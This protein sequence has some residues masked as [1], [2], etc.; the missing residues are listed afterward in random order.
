MHVSRNKVLTVFFLS[1]VPFLCWVLSAQGGTSVIDP[2]S[3]NQV[4][5]S[6]YDAAFHYDDCRTNADDYWDDRGENIGSQGNLTDAVTGKTMVGLEGIQLSNDGKNTKGNAAGEDY[7]L[8]FD[9]RSDITFKARVYVLLGIRHVFSET[10]EAAVKA[11]FDDDAYSPNKN[12]DSVHTDRTW[13]GLDKDGEPIASAPVFDK[14]LER[15]DGMPMVFMARNGIGEE[16]FAFYHDFDAGD[17]VGVYGGYSGG[18][19]Y[20]VFAEPVPSPDEPSTD[21]LP[22][23]WTSVE[24]GDDAKPGSAHFDWTNSEWIISGNGHDVWDSAD[25]FQYVYTEHSGDFTVQARFNWL[26]HVGND[27]GKIGLMVRDSADANSAHASIASRASNDYIGIQYRGST[28]SG[29]SGGL[30]SWPGAGVMPKWFRW[31]RAGN[32]FTGSL[33]DDGVNWTTHGSQDVTL[34]DPV[35]VGMSVTSHITGTLTTASYSNTYITGKGQVFAHAGSDQSVDQGAADTFDLNGDGCIEADEF[36][37][38]QLAGA[39][40]VIPDPSAQ[41]QTINTAAIDIFGNQTFVFRLT[42]TNT[43]SGATQTATIQVFVKDKEQADAGADQDAAESKTGAIVTVHLD[44]SATTGVITEW[45]W[46][47]VSGPDV[48]PIYNPDKPNPWFF[49]GDWAGDQVIQFRLTING[50]EDTDYVNINV[51]DAEEAIA[52]A[53]ADQE[54]FE[55]R[56]PLGLLDAT[57][58][59]TRDGEPSTNLS[60]WWDQVGGPSVYKFEG[61]DTT[62]PTFIAPEIPVTIRDRREWPPWRDLTFRVTV[63]A[64]NGSTGSD[65][66]TVTIKDHEF[67]TVLYR[68]HEDFD[69]HQTP[70]DGRWY[71]QEAEYG[72]HYAAGAVA[73]ELQGAWARINPNVDYWW[74]NWG[75]DHSY[76]DGVS[77]GTGGQVRDTSG[78]DWKCGWINPNEDDFWKYTFELPHGSTDAYLV[79]WMSS[80]SGDR[81]NSRMYYDYEQGNTAPVS[82]VR[83]MNR[84]WDNFFPRLSP[85]FEVTAGLHKIMIDAQP[86]GEPNY[87]RFELHLPMPHGNVANAGPDQGAASGELVVLNGT[88]SQGVGL[89]YTWEQVSG[90]PVT[91]AD[92]GSGVATFTAP[93]VADVV[94]LLFRLTVSGATNDSSDMVHVTVLPAGLGFS[95]FAEQ[96]TARDFTTT[97]WGDRGAGAGGAESGP[98]LETYGQNNRGILPPGYTLCSEVAAPGNRLTPNVV[99]HYNTFGGDQNND[100]YSEFTFVNPTGAGDYYYYMRAAYQNGDS[101]YIRCNDAIVGVWPTSN[102]DND[103]HRIANDNGGRGEYRYNWAKVRAN[104]V[105]LIDGENVVRIYGRESH[106]NNWMPFVWDAM[107]FSLVELDRG[108]FDQM[109]TIARAAQTGTTVNADAGAD[110]NV[111]EGQTAVLDGTGSSGPITSWQWAQTAGPGVTIT[112]D[113]Q[114]VATFV[115]PNVSGPTTATFELTVSD[116]TNS[117]SDTVDVLILEPGPPPPPTNLAAEGVELGIQLTWDASPGAVS[118]K[119]LRREV[120][121]PWPYDVLVAENFGGT[122]LPDTSM[123]IFMDMTY[124]YTVLGVNSFGVS[125]PAIPAQA[126][127]L[128]NNLALRGDAAPFAKRLRGGLDISIMNNEVTEEIIENDVNQESIDS[129]AGAQNDDW[130]GYWYPQPMYFQEFH[131]HPGNVLPDGGWWTSLGVQFTKDGVFWYDIP[132]ATITID[133]LYKFTPDTPDDR[134]PGDGRLPHVRKH[135]ISFP[136]VEGIA[137]RISGAPG[138]TADYTSVA[139]LKLYGVPG[140]EGYLYAFAGPDTSFDEGTTATLDGSDSATPVAVA[141]QWEQITGAGGQVIQL[142]M[143]SAFNSDVIYAEGEDLAAHDAFEPGG[144]NWLYSSNA[145]IAPAGTTPLPAD[146]VLGPFQLGPSAGNNNNCL[147]LSD[148]QRSGT[149]PVT[150]GNYGFLDVVFS[151]ASGNHWTRLYLNYANGD[152]LIWFEFS[153]W[154]NRGDVE[155]ALQNSFRVSRNDEHTGYGTGDPGGPNLYRRRIPVD[156]TRTLESITFS[157]FPG[158]GNQTGGVFAMNLG[159]AIPVLDLQNANSAVC[160]FNVPDMTHDQVVTFKLTVWDASNNSATDE[161]DVLLVDTQGSHP[162]PG[163]DATA[164]PFTSH[165]LDGSGTG[166]DIVWYRWEQIGGPPPV[167]L[168]N[169]DQAQ[170][171]IIVPPPGDPMTFKLT[172]GAANGTI[173]S[174]TVTISSAYPLNPDPYNIVYGPAALSAFPLVPSSGYIQDV[175][176]GGANYFS[177]FTSNLDVNYDH[178]AANGGQANQVPIAGQTI[179]IGGE[180][181]ADG[182]AVWTPMHRDDGVWLGTAEGDFSDFCA[183]FHVYIISPEQRDAR[184][185][186]RH[187]DEMRCWNNGAIAFQRD[188]WDDGAEQA[189][190]FTLYAGVN[191]MTFKIHEGGGGNNLNVRFADRNNNQYSDLRYV[192]SYDQ[193]L[194]SPVALISQPDPFEGVIVPEGELLY[195]DGRASEAP[196]MTYSLEQVWPLTPEFAFWSDLTS[197]PIAGAPFVDEDTVFYLRIWVDDGTNKNAD[198]AKVTVAT[199]QIPGAASNITGEWAGDVGAVLRWDPAA[200]AS[201]YVIERAEDAAGPYAIAGTAVGAVKFV[202]TGPLD[203]DGTYYYTITPASILNVGPAS[204]PIAISRDPSLGNAALSDKATPFAGQLNPLGGGS[205][206]IGIMNDGIVSGQNY[207]TYDGNTPNPGTLPGEETFEF[208]GYLFDDPVEIHSLVYYVGG[209][210]GNGG[211]W[212]TLGVLVTH[213]GGDTWR[214]APCF[215]TGPVYDTTDSGDGRSSN[216]KYIISI[217]PDTVGGVRIAGNAGGSAHFVSIAELEAYGDVGGLNV[218]AGADGTSDEGLVVPLDG[219]AT[220]GATDVLWTHVSGPPAVI[221]NADQQ[222]ASFTAPGVFFSDVVTFRLTASNAQWSAWDE[223]SFTILDVDSYH[224]YRY[225]ADFDGR[226][227]GRLTYAAGDWG[228]GVGFQHDFVQRMPDI[229]ANEAANADAV[230]GNDY[231][232]QATSEDYQDYRPDLNPFDV[233]FGDFGNG[234]DEPFIGYTTV[235]DWWNYSF[236]MLSKTVDTSFPV[237]GVMAITALAASGAGDTVVEVYLEEQLVT[238]INFWGNNWGDFQWR[239]GADTFLVTATGTRTIRLKL[240][241]GGWDFCKIRLDLSEPQIESITKVDDMATLKWSDVGRTYMLQQSDYPGGPWTNIFGWTPDTSVT[242]PIPPDKLMFYRIEV[243]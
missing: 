130:W 208:F 38:E 201:R 117:D 70:Q 85:P 204:S 71:P 57:G 118:Y 83:I 11:A 223:V 44:G 111:L 150:P 56:G 106:M 126:Y 113:D 50:G 65:T 198:V 138:G 243:Q 62:N 105:T 14:V 139:E 179:N 209:V 64:P 10:P 86:P 218:N 191:C 68:E 199:K 45:L 181:F 26:H 216:E 238:T 79:Q 197:L 104:T 153:D 129:A 127:A 157:D 115:A 93:A 76:R 1:F 146:G 6:G 16:Y 169:A 158:N 164:K 155:R 21:N 215:V 80:G 73:T 54:A 96:R 156:S 193:L 203:P 114:P 230:T 109:D 36:L 82:T 136:K 116:G 92:A 236:G 87:A 35:L 29:S 235:N 194:P 52:N 144:D 128:S 89:T 101:A 61:R 212:T 165:I 220:T 224:I 195:L 142:N 8:N 162:D 48:A 25:D 222:V 192:T 163:P 58:S 125:A 134:S 143:T 43:T 12:A 178:L 7:E 187:D 95:L 120:G 20:F 4:N 46:E 196:G 226:V 141:Y 30:E 2:G 221:N 231:F 225:T 112:D 148:Q 103:H 69:F 229:P 42:A 160:T 15:L 233:R 77:L 219:S 84:G 149:L 171:T 121:V 228:T 3:I 133:P 66:A 22:A 88:G 175:L 123:P 137:V 13:I 53:G 81:G 102:P 27:W 152:S 23:I 78:T 242:A 177:R 211:W 188:G 75:G 159:P 232:F 189:L 60:Y 167:A 206:D 172:V 40:N 119:I 207:D 107:I 31:E 19:N 98:D 161:I 24:I 182:P 151:G 217:T 110:F 39:P 49:T 173:S 63:T 234:V 90:D 168:F 180:T 174:D 186:I 170:A 135:I 17:A 124:S 140:D 41:S 147:L 240:V 213:D 166:G 205:R 154:F 28:G 100:C 47:Q 132:D 91:L 176:M 5:P 37:W 55:M 99:V 59:T 122:L 202:D 184:A 34:T 185:I 108:N 32:T 74:N 72:V 214:D 9:I 227:T 241:Q 200:H 67:E 51:E 237:D 210:F 183:Y 18:S 94:D 97:D 131:Y 33:S 239:P 145:T 190:D